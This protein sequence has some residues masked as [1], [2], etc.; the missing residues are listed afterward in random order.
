MALAAGHGADVGPR[1][2]DDTIRNG[3]VVRGFD[4]ASDCEKARQTGQ[5]CVPAL[6]LVNR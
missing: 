5:V 2:L 4:T 3:R 6:A 1:T